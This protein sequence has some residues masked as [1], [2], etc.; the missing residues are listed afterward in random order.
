MN[1]RTRGNPSGE[2][3]ISE[4]K[5]LSGCRYSVGTTE[6]GLTLTLYGLVDLG[7]LLAG[8]AV[9]A[10]QAVKTGQASIMDDM[11]TVG[12]L[13][14]VQNMESAAKSKSRL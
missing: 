5:P 14:S 7:P 8:V 10:A 2:Y 13:R 6:A 11:S 3:W 1:R 12:P 9:M 4:N